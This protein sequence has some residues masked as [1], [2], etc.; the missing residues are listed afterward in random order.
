MTVKE[1]GSSVCVSISL[2]VKI[3]LKNIY[4]SSFRVRFEVRLR[5]IS[6]PFEHLNLIL[7]IMSFEVYDNNFCG[8]MTDLM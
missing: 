4:T 1:L 8:L 3:E 7:L 2:S 5:L 6:K